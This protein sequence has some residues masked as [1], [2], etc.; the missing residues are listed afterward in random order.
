MERYVLLVSALVFIHG[1]FSY[2]EETKEMTFS[3]PHPDS[4]PN[5][6]CICTIK[7][8]SLQLILFWL[9]LFYLVSNNIQYLTARN[10]GFVCWRLDCERSIFPRKSAGERQISKR[11]NV[12]VAPT[13]RSQ[14]RSHAYFFCVISHGFSRETET[15]RSL[16]DASKYT[17]KY[18]LRT[19]NTQVGCSII[20]DS[21][22]SVK[23]GRLR[24]WRGKLGA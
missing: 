21:N 2:A 10:H 16:I 23:I 12:T 17:Q 15:V 13:S 11:A 8:K 18:Q 24:F 14:S 9:H 3:V 5:D 4:Q 1:T 19:L 22:K 20:Y 7:S 6:V